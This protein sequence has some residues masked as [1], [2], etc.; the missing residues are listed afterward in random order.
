MIASPLTISLSR[1]FTP[2]AVCCFGILLASTSFYLASMA[3]SLVTLYC[4]F[5]IMFGL[6]SSFS[7][8]TTIIVLRANFKRHLPL[9]YAIGISG[10]GAGGM[11]FSLLLPSLFEA[12]GWRGSLRFLSYVTL[13]LIVCGLVLV[14]CEQKTEVIDN[15]D[16]A[17]AKKKS[18]PWKEKT[19]LQKVRR[20]LI[21]SSWRNE[22]FLALNV[23]L[24]LLYF[25]LPVPYCHIV[26]SDDFCFYFQKEICKEIFGV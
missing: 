24:I 16:D 15:D 14:P 13:A 1:R 23:A 20:V 7:H 4:T 2:R 26:S 12:R 6:A 11:I 3:T 25:V 9:A 19:G 10:S 18:T 17:K 22:A 8:L 21:P 5:G